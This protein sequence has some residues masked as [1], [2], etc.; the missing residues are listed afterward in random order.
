MECKSMAKFGGLCAILA[1]IAY[2][3]IGVTYLLQP[4]AQ[5]AGVG[6]EFL[7][8]VAEGH[9]VLMITYWAFALASLFMIGAVMAISDRVRE[10]YEGWVRWTSTL[11]II[12]YAVTAAA[13]LLLQD[14][15][16]RLAAAY[17]AADESAR[18]ALAAMG[19]RSLDPDYWLGF[20]VAG[21][22]ALSVNWL[23]IRGGQFPKPLAYVGLLAGLAHL[24]VVAGGVL[25]VPVLI[26]ISAG[27][28]GIIFGPI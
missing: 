8:S 21:L 22:W 15:T 25:E 18:A 23:A 12:G 24:L 10:D 4:E 3:V 11:A 26:A 13:F 6:D 2:I 5:Q 9:T 1:G 19:P 14:H 16:P 7:T 27:L 28:G 17:V 20:G